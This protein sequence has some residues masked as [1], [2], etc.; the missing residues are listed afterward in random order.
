MLVVSLLSACGEKQEVETS[1]SSTAE[2]E[3]QENTPA[4]EYTKGKID[5]DKK[6]DQ[7]EEIINKNN[8]LIQRIEKG[9]S[10]AIA[11]QEELQ[12]LR[13]ELEGDINPFELKESQL[14]PAQVARLA[15]LQ[16]KQREETT[17][18]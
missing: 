10:T 4:T 12:K 15:E 18:R 1:V 9:D 13:K 3:L 7:F 6:L 17:S 14:T 8:E 16:K 11:E 2:Q 5:W